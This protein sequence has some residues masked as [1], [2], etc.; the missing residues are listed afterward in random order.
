MR[1]YVTKDPQG[2]ASFTPPISDFVTNLHFTGAGAKTVSWPSGSNRCNISGASVYWVRKL[3]EGLTVNTTT[4]GS[5]PYTIATVA[6][7]NSGG[8]GY[9]VGDILPLAIGSSD[10][11]ATVTVTAMN[12]DT[13]AVTG[14]S[15]TSAGSYAADVSGSNGATAFGSAAKPSADVTNGTGSA[16]STPQRTRFMSENKFT[17]YSE[18]AQEVSIEFWTDN[19]HSF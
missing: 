15:L 17:V 16:R 19:P 10:T 13:G 12:G 4:A 6:V 5:G 9:S 2:Y 11:E 1:S 8:T 3:A 14:L 7:G 18:A